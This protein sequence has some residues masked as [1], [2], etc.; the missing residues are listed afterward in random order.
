MADRIDDAIFDFAYELAMRDATMRT[1]FTGE[2]IYVLLGKRNQDTK[3]DSTPAQKKN[4]ELA[5]EAVRS[6]IEG[7]RADEGYE[8]RAQ[9]DKCFIS[10]ARDVINAFKDYK[11]NGSSFEFGNAQKLINMTT[12]YIAIGIYMRNCRNNF[13]YCHCPMDSIIMDKAAKAAGKLIDDDGLSED[14]KGEVIESLEAFAY[15]RPRAHDWV[16]KSE[17]SWSKI[18]FDDRKSYD[19]FQEVV[20][21]LAAKNGYYPLEFDYFIWA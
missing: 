11:N 2:S 14:E 15:K 7:I 9:H 1:A 19:G 20:R 21:F 3:I 4:A 18:T 12:K 6:Y 5:K 10:I 16:A 8:H 17:V 13:Q